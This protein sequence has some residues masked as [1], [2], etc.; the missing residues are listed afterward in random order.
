MGLTFKANSSLCINDPMPRYRRITVHKRGKGP[1][2]VSCNPR[3]SQIRAN[4]AVSGYAS[5]RYLPNRIVDLLVKPWT[6]DSRRRMRSHFNIIE[7][8]ELRCDDFLGSF[9][10]VEVDFVSGEIGR[11]TLRLVSRGIAL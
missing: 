8:C 2:N 3:A 1:S 11:W 9:S 10:L 5:S 4:V 6:D 7:V